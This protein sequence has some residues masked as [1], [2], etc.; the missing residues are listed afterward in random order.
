MRAAPRPNRTPGGT[1]GND[2]GQDDVEKAGAVPKPTHCKLRAA[3]VAE[4][5]RAL[6]Q[7][8]GGHW[9]AQ[10][11]CSEEAECAC[12]LDQ[13][14]GWHPGRI[15]AKES[16]ATLLEMAKGGGAEAG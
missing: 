9:S 7:K 14:R 11:Q 15:E 16:L 1:A 3:H 2:Q 4:C 5:T 8:Q 6:G 12:A 10:Q 13:E